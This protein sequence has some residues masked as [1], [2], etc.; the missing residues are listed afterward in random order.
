MLNVTVPVSAIVFV[1][2][3]SISVPVDA[4]NVPSIVILPATFNVVDGNASVAV[5][6]TVRSP[7]TVVAAIIVFAF[8][9]PLVR[10]RLPKVTGGIGR[11]L[12]P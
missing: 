10:T 4:F 1:A 6:L 5:E 2:P 12:D 8:D 3:S 7:N 11:A 9:P